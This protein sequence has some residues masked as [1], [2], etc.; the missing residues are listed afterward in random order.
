M[1]NLIKMKFALVLALSL[2]ACGSKSGGNTGGN[3]GN[4]GN[5]GNAGNAGNVQGVNVTLKNLRQAAKDNGF[6]VDVSTDSPNNDSNGKAVDPVAGVWAG[7]MQDG[8][9]KIVVYI[10]EFASEQDALAYKWAMDKAEIMIN[11]THT[12]KQ[13]CV[14]FHE[15]AYYKEAQ[16]MSAFAALGWVDN[17]T[18]APPSAADVPPP[19]DPSHIL[20]TSLTLAQVKANA[21]AA[22]YATDDGKGWV[23]DGPATP[24]NGFEFKY[25]NLTGSVSVLEFASESEAQ[26]YAAYAKHSNGDSWHNYVQGKLVLEFSPWPDDNFTADKESRMVAALF[27]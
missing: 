4:T 9:N 25:P 17:T 14:E 10:L 6:V 16:L 3:T 24:G 20:S 19:I 18:P 26:A 12:Y 21:E 15:E 5:A 22:G 7:L 11:H 2:V 1:R 27:K 13:F 8:V 23:P